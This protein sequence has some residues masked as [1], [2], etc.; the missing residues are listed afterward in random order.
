MSI[1]SCL[2]PVSASRLKTGIFRPCCTMDK[3]PQRQLC[4]PRARLK[5]TVP[6]PP[7]PLNE[8]LHFSK[9]PRR[10][11]KGEWGPTALPAT[12]GLATCVPDHTPFLPPPAPPASSLTLCGWR[13]SFFLV[14]LEGWPFCSTRPNTAMCVPH[15]HLDKFFHFRWGSAQC[16]PFQE[17]FSDYSP[18]VMPPLSHRTS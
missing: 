1:Y 16:H 13:Q 7:S 18:H 5:C 17:A 15:M 14:V 11:C 9:V 6:G 12:L 3:P 4:H 8:H 2:G 10:C